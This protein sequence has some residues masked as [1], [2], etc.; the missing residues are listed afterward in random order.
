M[1]VAIN[2]FLILLILGLTYLLYLS[3]LEPIKFEKNKNIRE[4]AVVRKLKSIRTSQELYR[5]I[6]GEFAF[7]FDTLKQV[8]RTEK[9]FTVNLIEDPEDPENPDKMLRD[10]SYFNTMD[11][12]KSLGISLDSLEF[13]P[14]SDGKVF[15]MIADT[16][17]YQQA[18]VHVTEVGVPRS[19]FMGEWGDPRFAKY[20]DSF[21]PNKVIKFGDMSAPSLAGNWE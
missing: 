21:D 16:I 10:T 3:I 2:I 17:R 13:V 7:S 19:I 14:F 18:L 8:L 11:S 15:T 1:R 12:L 20:D 6:T 5:D 4:G 9:L